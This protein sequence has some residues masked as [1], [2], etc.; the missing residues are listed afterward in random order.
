MSRRRLLGNVAVVAAIAAVFAVAGLATR[1]R[2]SL[3]ASPPPTSASATSAASATQSTPS[4]VSSGPDPLASPA[5]PGSTA[6]TSTTV[7][8]PAINHVYTIVMENHEASSILDNRAASY[9]DG[10]A[11]TY[12]L[13]ANFTAVAHPSEPNYVAMFA[14]STLGVTDDG[15]HTFRGVANLADQIEGAGRDWRVAAQNVPLDCFTGSS[16]SD[17]ADGKG[18]Y[19][20]KHEPA[21]MFSQIANEP[22]RCAKITD[23]SHFDPNVG[24]YWFIV[25]NLCNDMHDC[26]VATG[27]RFLGT[28]VPTI[29]DSAAFRQDGLIFLTFDEGSSNLGGGGKVVTIVISPKVRAGYRSDTAYD[30]YSVL[31]TIEA[32]WGMPCL[33][34]A[35]SATPMRDLFP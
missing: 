11:S 33:A 23:F 20:R 28:F 17:G 6:P 14:G 15:T 1:D 4:V 19:G 21:I 18:T 16:A 25:P 13:A 7:A 27:D 35:C 29:L 3:R 12:G 32:M 34:N 2:S 10:L 22:T 30:H 5:P 26:P 9:I 31:R 24:N 8:W